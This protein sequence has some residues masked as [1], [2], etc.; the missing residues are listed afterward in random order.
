MAFVYFIVA[1]ALSLC[2]YPLAGWTANYGWE[3]F[4]ATTSVEAPGMWLFTGL[5]LISTLWRK[6]GKI[7]KEDYENDDASWEYLTHVVR[8][9]VIVFIV[10]I[11]IWVLSH[12]V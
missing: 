12:F 11:H 10:Q 5:L 9:Y 6:V 8:Y 2:W 7:N 1:F 4:I 3:V